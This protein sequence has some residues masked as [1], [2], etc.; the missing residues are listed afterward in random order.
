ML[1]TFVNQPGVPLVSVSLTCPASN[2]TAV[3]LTERRFLVDGSSTPGELW[4][5]PLCYAF[6][7]TKHAPNA[8]ARSCTVMSNA[9]AGTAPRHR[10][11]PPLGVVDRHPRRAQ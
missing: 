9:S 3:T 10:G 4:Q 11:G 7:A 8:G 1:P 2:A 6:A 5:I